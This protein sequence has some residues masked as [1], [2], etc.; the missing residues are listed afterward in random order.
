V[1]A[2]ARHRGVKESLL[3]AAVDH[4]GRRGATALEAYPHVR[5]D[6]MGVPSL[7]ERSG[8]RAVRAVEPRLVMRRRLSRG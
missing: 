4:A 7:F 5:G 3:D 8:F 1:H 6:Y 2:A